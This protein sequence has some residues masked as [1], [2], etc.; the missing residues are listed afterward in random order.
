MRWFILSVSI[1]L[2]VG[3]EEEPILLPPTNLLAENVYLEVLTEVHLYNA[4]VQS[5]DSVAN[6]DSLRLALYDHY[7]VS[8]DQFL[9]SH[10][11]YQSQVMLQKVRL[12]SVSSR[13]KRSLEA[14]NEAH[15]ATNSSG[16]SA[17][18][19]Q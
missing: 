14:L 1:I 10:T 3:C 7:Q 5:A 15:S 11:Y 17:R 8:E 6:Q 9:E 2:S 18:V 13:L 19:F 16:G 12:D 4:L